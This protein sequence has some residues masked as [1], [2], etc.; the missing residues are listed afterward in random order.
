MRYP[1]ILTIF[2]FLLA[3]CKKDKFSTIPQLKYKSVNTKKLSRGEVITF[4]LSFTDAEGD[5]TDSLFVQQFVR[6]CLASNLKRPLYKLPEF[7]T[8]K[9]QE[10]EILVTYGYEVNGTVP[11]VSPKCNRN[12][13][14][15]FRFVLK[16]K[17]QNKSDTVSSDPIIIIR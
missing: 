13:T 5:L 15:I 3:G 16:D 2:I 10:G 14:A 7:P 11:L 1:I 12:D 9:N 8:S 6:N 17:A 4:T